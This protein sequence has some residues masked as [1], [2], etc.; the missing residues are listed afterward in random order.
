MTTN[1]AINLN[2][3]GLA[4]YDGTGVFSGITLTDGQIP[5]GVTGAA[6]NPNTLTGGFG[7]VVDNSTPGEIVIS[8][9]GGGFSWSTTSVNVATMNAHNGYFAIS[10]GGALTFGLPPVSS[11]GDAITLNLSGA[12]S[13]QITQPNAGSQIRLGNQTTTLGVGGTLTSTAQGDSIT[14]V[15]R[16]A[17]GIWEAVASIGNLTY[18]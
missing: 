15:C 6:P 10:P 14:L 7:I 1:N 13:W 3:A 11:I 9:T 16:T 18:A 8:S 17:N 12:T 2:D 4:Y 5:I